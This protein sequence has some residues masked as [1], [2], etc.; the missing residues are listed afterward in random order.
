L[1]RHLDSIEMRKF[2][3]H[4]RLPFGLGFSSPRRNRM[5]AN[6]SSRFDKIKLWDTFRK[7]PFAVVCRTLYHDANALR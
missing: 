6:S 4:E 1:K 3:F 2:L 5:A 7:R